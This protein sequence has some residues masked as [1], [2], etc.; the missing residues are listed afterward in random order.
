MGSIF[1]RHHIYPSFPDECGAVNHIGGGLNQ[2]F[3]LHNAGSVSVL[4][5]PQLIN[6][7]DRLL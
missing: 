7:Q 5:D 2:L 4:T 3:L 1:L 6:G